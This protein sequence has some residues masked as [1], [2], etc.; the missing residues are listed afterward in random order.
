[1]YTEPPEIK[2]ARKHIHQKLDPIWKNGNI[3]RNQ[4]YKKLSTILGWKY[5]TA[6]IRSIE[7]AREVYKAVTTMQ[8]VLGI[9]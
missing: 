3:S 9:V 4:L 1:M 8:E 2:N 5:H 7:E 6:N